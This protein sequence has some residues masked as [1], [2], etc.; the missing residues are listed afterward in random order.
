MLEATVRIDF[1][2]DWHVGSGLGDGA[3]ADAILNRDA[4]GLPW[5]PGR[6]VKG[7]LREAAWRVGL[8][9]SDL[10]RMVEVVFGTASTAR[11]SNT[12]GRISVGSGHLPRDLADWLVRSCDTEE[13]A[14]YVRDM[15]VPRVQTMLDENGMVVP[16]SLRTIEC[17]IPG[18]YFISHVALDIPDNAR[19][20]FL[21]YLGALCAAVKSIGAD[22]ARGLGRCRLTVGGSGGAVDLPS[23]VDPGLLDMEASA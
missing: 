2:S 18:L 14:Q 5:I 12:P 20:W 7:A 1:F 3:I 17:G 19:E 21:G 22:R 4:D 15:T 10:A 6:A 8:C 13:R 11:A 9:R 16:H 23:P